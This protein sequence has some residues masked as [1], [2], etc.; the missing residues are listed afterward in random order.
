MSPELQPMPL[1]YYW[2][3]SPSVS[4]DQYTALQ[5]EG[6]LV[7]WYGRMFWYNFDTV[8]CQFLETGTSDRCLIG[9]VQLLRFSGFSLYPLSFFLYSPFKESLFEENEQQSCLLGRKAISSVWA[10]YA[11]YRY[12]SGGT[13]STPRGE[14]AYSVLHGFM[15]IHSYQYIIYYTPATFRGSNFLLCF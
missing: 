13:D 14:T 15:S 11:G 1:Q 6:V 7:T 2:H 10:N 3:M 12:R 5:L 4:R 8:L 9:I